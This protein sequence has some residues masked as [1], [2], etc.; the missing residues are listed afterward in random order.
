MAITLIL[1]IM[2]EEPIVG[3]V[4]QMPTASDIAIIL[5]NPR[6]RDGKD[7]PNLSSS[8]VTTVMFPMNRMTFV[9]VMPSD[10]EE[11]I[12]GVVRE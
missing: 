8:N 4:E 9:E 3:E 6:R 2:N 10:E 1:H 11:K 5:Q 7:M 12:F